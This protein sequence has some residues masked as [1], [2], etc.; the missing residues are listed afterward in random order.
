MTSNV[1]FAE[2]PY[3]N[4]LTSPFYNESHRKWQKTCREFITKH[5]LDQAFEWD[6]Q[7]DVPQDVFKKFAEAGFLPASLPAP[8]PV[9]W[10]KD[11]GIHTLPGGLTVEDYDYFHFLIFTDEVSSKSEDFGFA[12]IDVAQWSKWSSWCHHCRVL[13]WCTAFL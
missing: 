3:L 1:P 5:L 9:K 4:N 7:G 6:D 8:L 2:P 13:I 11:H 12:N 10:L